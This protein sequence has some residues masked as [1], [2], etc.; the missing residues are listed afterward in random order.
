MELREKNEQRSFSHEV[1]QEV[2]DADKNNKRPYICNGL[3]LQSK[4]L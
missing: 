1:D 3:N 2:F 4:V